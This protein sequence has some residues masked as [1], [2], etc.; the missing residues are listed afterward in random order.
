MT[1][2][3]FWL[4]SHRW[5]GI[6]A[7]PLLVLI[8][9]TGSALVFDHAIDEWLHPELLLCDAAGPN[10]PLDQLIAAAEA[11]YNSATPSGEHVKVT[12]V[13]SPRIAGGVW[14]AWFTGGTEA[15]PFYTAVYIDP[16]TARVTG[17]RVWGHD[18]MSWIYRLHFQLVSGQVGATIVGVL[19]LILLISIVSGILVWWPL[20]RHSVRAAIAIRGGRRFIYDLHKTIGIVSTVL[21]AVLALTGVTMEFPGAFNRVLSV[22][23]ARTSEP[24]DLASQTDESTDRLSPEEAIAI[25]RKMYPDARFCHFHPPADDR[26]VY[27]VAVHQDDEVQRSYGRTQ[28]FIDQYD[29]RILA[30]RLPQNDT[31]ADQIAVWQ[32][33]LHNG[34]AFGLVG[35]W[36][37]LIAGLT[38][39]ILYATGMLV[40]VRKIWSRRRVSLMK[41]PGSKKWMP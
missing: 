38:P 19:G 40:W 13:S 26:G 16:A 32:F 30:R 28:L 18:V 31:I 39:A 11:S 7:G 1:A 24:T 29:G 14:T 34:E 25:A 27:E 22:L 21:L 12:S 6:V 41:L 35:R 5:L 2:R 10:R 23:S 9:L 4:V 33:P 36:V 8:G 15:E 20:W 3:R 17:T 37:V